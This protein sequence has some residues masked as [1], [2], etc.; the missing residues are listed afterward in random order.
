MQLA[1][2]F[3]ICCVSVGVCLNGGGLDCTES[4]TVIGIV[5]QQ[6]K[7]FVLIIEQEHITTTRYYSRKW[8]SFRILYKR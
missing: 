5:S 4:K 7:R 6:E 2:K 1:S 8:L 3:A